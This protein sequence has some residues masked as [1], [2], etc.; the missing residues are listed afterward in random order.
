MTKQNEL[1][2]NLYASGKK[3]ITINRNGDLEMIY[4]KIQNTKEFRAF[5]D[6]HFGQ[7]TFRE[8]VDTAD[9]KSI[10]EDTTHKRKKR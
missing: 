7:S 4:A 10:D 8:V 5:E 6:T 1:L 2:D 3:I 9:E